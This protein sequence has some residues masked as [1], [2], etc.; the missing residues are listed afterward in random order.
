MAT[1]QPKK[2]GLDSA[3]EFT[4]FVITLDSGLIAFLTGTTFLALVHEHW[5]IV[6]VLVSLAFLIASIAAGVFVYMRVATKLSDGD[7]DLEDPWLSIPGAVNVICFAAGTV[8]VAG[9]AVVKLI[10]K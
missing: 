5:E 10:V 1:K 8:G 4:K 9:L 6:A 3:L 2:E 7:Y